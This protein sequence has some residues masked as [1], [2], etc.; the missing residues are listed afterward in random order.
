[1]RPAHH[2]TTADSAVAPAV[3]WNSL[4]ATQPPICC[5]KFLIN[6]QNG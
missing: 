3:V 5:I 1:M 2:E 6:V 4:W